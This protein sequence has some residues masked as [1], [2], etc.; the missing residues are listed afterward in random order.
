MDRDGFDMRE[1]M[2]RLEKGE[3]HT[4]IVSNEMGT[5]HWNHLRVEDIVKRWGE[6]AVAMKEKTPP[7][8]DYDI[9][10]SNSKIKRLYDKNL[11]TKTEKTKVDNRLKH[12]PLSD[13]NPPCLVK[14]DWNCAYCAFAKRCWQSDP[15]ELS[16]EQVNA[17]L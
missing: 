5:Y 1:H 8:R 2:V 11:L 14:G 15:S 4:P 9:Q 17:E 3:Y 16:E 6:L 10:Y 13:D 7:P 12:G